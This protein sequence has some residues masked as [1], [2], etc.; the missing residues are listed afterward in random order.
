MLCGYDVELRNVKNGE[1]RIAESEENRNPSEEA[2][3][4]HWNGLHCICTK[5]RTLF[6][7]QVYESYEV[8]KIMCQSLN[9]CIA[10]RA[11]FC[12]SWYY[13]GS[14]EL[15]ALSSSVPIPHHNQEIKLSNSHVSVN[16]RVARRRTW[17]WTEG[18]A[19]T[20]RKRN[21]RWTEEE[22]VAE[23]EDGSRTMKWRLW[24]IG[25][26]SWEDDYAMHSWK[27][28]PSFVQSARLTSLEPASRIAHPR[29]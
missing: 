16:D 1:E 27:Q 4:K 24:N 14:F 15:R 17:S 18:K 11:A 10:R 6:E 7:M 20:F 23:K 21:H 22:T 26:W 19:K 3:K 9:L 28:L 2:M 8:A 5:C 25:E 12:D 29:K 13:F